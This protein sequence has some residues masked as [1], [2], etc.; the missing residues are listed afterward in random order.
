MV[1]PSSEAFGLLPIIPIL[2][3]GR[4]GLQLVMGSPAEY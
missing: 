3:T 1:L 4:I 2:V